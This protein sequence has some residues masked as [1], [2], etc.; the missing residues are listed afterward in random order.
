MAR[1]YLKGARQETRAYS[2]ASM[3]CFSLPLV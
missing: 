1:E 2:P 3:P